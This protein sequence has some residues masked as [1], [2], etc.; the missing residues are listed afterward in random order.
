MNTKKSKFMA[1][2]ENKNTD[3]LLDRLTHL[4]Y[5]SKNYFSIFSSI[6]ISSAISFFVAILQISMNG[7][8]FFEITNSALEYCKLIFL[9]G[10]NFF[11]ILVGVLWSTAIVLTALVPILLVIGF[12]AHA[13]KTVFE[14]DSFNIIHILQFVIIKL[15]CICSIIY[16]CINM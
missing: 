1:S 16:I 11:Q 7:E 5:K 3:Y 8:N 9:N 14:M 2:E 15:N 13:S 12:L 10:D 6:L 4:E